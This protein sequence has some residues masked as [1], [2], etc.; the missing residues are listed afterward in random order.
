M[1]PRTD[2]LQGRRARAGGE[3]ARTSRSSFPNSRRTTRRPPAL[4]RRVTFNQVAG[5]WP[6]PLPPRASPSLALPSRLSTCVTAPG[7]PGSRPLPL[8]RSRAAPYLEGPGGPSCAT[9]RLV[10]PLR[11]SDWTRLTRPFDRVGRRSHPEP[12]PVLAVFHRLD[13][14]TKSSLQAC[15]IP[16]PTL[17]FATFPGSATPKTRSPFRQRG[18]AAPFEV[19]LETSRT[20]S[21]RPPTPFTLDQNMPCRLVAAPASFFSS[22]M[23]EPAEADLHVRARVRR[24]GSAY[25][26]ADRP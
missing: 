10:P 25:V 17:G 20:A 24:A 3:E 4:A 22:R 19:L 1:L 12:T 18:R 15:C 7:C 2:P 14:P 23:L 21:P 5:R 9:L 6:F 26:S 11:R 16:L 13:G 8:P